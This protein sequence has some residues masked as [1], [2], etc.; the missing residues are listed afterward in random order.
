MY[1]KMGFYD[2]YLAAEMQSADLTMVVA[3]TF[4]SK[5]FPDAD[6]WSE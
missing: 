2:V 3:C 6:S 4:M 5:R 1:V